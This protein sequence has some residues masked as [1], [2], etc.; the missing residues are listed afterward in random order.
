MVLLEING[1]R[2]QISENAF[3][4]PS[5][6]ILGDVIIHDNVIIWPGAIIRGDNAPINIGEYST[7][8]DGVIL[9]TRSPKCSIHIGRY[10]IIETGATILGCFME[11]YVQIL[12]GTLI[13]EESSVGEGVVILK[14]SEVPPGLA[15]PARSVLKGRPVEKM[16]EQTRN[17]VLD[18][19]ERAHHY[20]QLF[21]RIKQH[22]PNA[23]GYMLTYPDFIKLLLERDKEKI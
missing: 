17:D 3:V 21:I 23:Q 22:L 10:C 9:F 14:D 8:F 15:I 16:R 18:Q 4:S 19:K 1:K 7:I 20:S 11:D 5:A 13:H 6:T 2:P 12:E